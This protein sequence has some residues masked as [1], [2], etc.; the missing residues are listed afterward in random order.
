MNIV[1]RNGIPERGGLMIRSRKPFLDD[2][3]IVRIIRQQLIPLNPP[4]LRPALSDKQLKSRLDAG[5]T[6]V[7]VP[8]EHPASRARGFVTARAKNGEL[9]VDML[10]LDHH[11][12]GRGA[13]TQLLRRAER[14]GVSRGCRRMR[15][16]VNDDNIRGIQFYH[17]QGMQP[18][19]YE[20]I[21]RSYVMEKRI[22]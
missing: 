14:Y 21:I 17:K 22:G 20:R 7:W 6:F 13:G 11:V 2:A 12:Q 3:G 16:F 9:F 5:L 1:E 18:V 19:S 10:A 8:D 4:E 15:L